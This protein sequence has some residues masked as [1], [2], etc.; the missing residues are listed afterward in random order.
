MGKS[1]YPDLYDEQTLW[2]R[3][4]KGNWETIISSRD[5]NKITVAAGDKIEIKSNT[6][7]SQT[8]P[9]GNLVYVH[10][11]SGSTAGFTLSG[12]IKSL[13]TT[14]TSESYSSFT[15][16]SYYQFVELFAGCTGLTSAKDLYMEA[17][18][19]RQHAF[20][21]M[22]SGCINL[23]EAPILY[24]DTLK[25][26]SYNGMFKGCSKL[27]T[28]TCYATNISATNCLTGWVNGVSST[29]TFYKKTGAT[30]PSGTSGIPDGWTVVEV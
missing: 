13:L 10:S 18:T 23:I 14:G 28:I 16:T 17:T 7:T 3:K 26:N 12:N 29:G 4:N 8:D 25:T 20:P 19:V 30:W 21:R 24:A 5:G 1:N 11:F 15:S 9:S 2:Y 6:Q 27:S 22:F